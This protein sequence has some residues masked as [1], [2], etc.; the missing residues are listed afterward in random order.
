MSKV[1]KSYRGRSVLSFALAGAAAATL[2]GRSADVSGFSNPFGESAR[3]GGASDRMATGA[4]RPPEAI[5]RGASDA[6]PEIAAAPT[7]R[8]AYAP[9]A[10]VRSVSSAPL[11]PVRSYSPYAAASA[12]GLA[13]PAPA[14]RSYARSEAPAVSHGSAVI[15]TEHGVWSAEG[16]SMVTVRPGENAAILATRYNVP[17][18]VFMRANGFVSAAQARPGAQVVIPIYSAGLGGR[19]HAA[20]AEEAPVRSRSDRGAP[21]RPI[22]PGRKQVASLAPRGRETFRFVKGASGEPAG[23]QAKQARAVGRKG[24]D[25]T[26]LA[27]QEAVELKANARSHAVAARAEPAQI[28]AKP[29]APAHGVDRTATASLPPAG[30]EA[31]A[32]PRRDAFRWPVRGRIIEGFKQG[33]NEGINI[34][35]PDGTNVKAADDGIVAYAGNE[36]KGYGNLVLIRHPNGFVTAYANN[37]EIDVKRGEIVKRG[38]V[39]AKSGAS[40]NVSSPQLH[41]ELRKGQTPVDPTT[42]LAGS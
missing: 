36:L 23:P 14:Y 37:G 2:A 30:V 15:K 32:G 41:F 24:Q 21:T 38:Q 4:I 16:G 3:L 39:I 28:A 33:S 11:A 29:V 18:D 17:L 1:V 22:E 26:R 27:K 42:F 8:V 10:P 25:E 12:P 34:A 40:G 35:V 7:G 19:T 31:D 20:M 9:L 13:S 5:G 6:G